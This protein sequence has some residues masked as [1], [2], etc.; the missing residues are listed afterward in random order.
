[1][2]MCISY[3]LVKAYQKLIEI[4]LCVSSLRW[5]TC[6]LHDLLLNQAIVLQMKH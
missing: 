5:N 1:M 4:A 2:C 3:D 6:I